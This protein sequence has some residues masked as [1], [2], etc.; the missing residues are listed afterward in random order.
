MNIV[1]WAPHEAGCLLACASSDGRVSIL[2]FQEG[3]W[4]HVMYDAHV[5]GANA[6]SWAPAQAAGSLVSSKPEL[7]AQ[8]RFVTGGSD[9]L[10]K[11]WD[12]K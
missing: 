11:I 12:W 10:V 5:G 6:V 2:E 4:S 8:R 9:C 3:N 1:A 7:A